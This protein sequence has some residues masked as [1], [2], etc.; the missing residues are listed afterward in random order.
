ML[1]LDGGLWGLGVFLMS[2]MEGGIW[3]WFVDVDEEM[4]DVC[5]DEKGTFVWEWEVVLKR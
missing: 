2:W 3:D 4:S 1:R 5:E